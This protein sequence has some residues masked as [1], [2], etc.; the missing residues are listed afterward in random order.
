MAP[1]RTNE[2][3]ISD[4]SDDGAARDAAIQY[5]I[6]WLERRLFFYLRERSDLA[7]VN[8]DELHQMAADFAQDSVLIIIEK[9]AQFAGRSKFTTWAAKIAVHQALGEMRR[10]RWRDLSL[11]ELTQNGSFEPRFL[12]SDQ[13][14][15]ETEAIQKQV[16]AIVMDVMQRDLS[17][18]QRLALYSRLVLGVPIAI[19]AEQM[20]TN[21]NALYKLIHDGRKR[22]KE[23]LLEKGISPEEVLSTFR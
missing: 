3:W 6:T 18:R 17:E 1:E 7:R 14:S 4:L 22:L 12:S 16:M 5:L 15:P 10:A 2:Q 20:Q 21:T 13:R 19:L 9:Y 23:R 8:A 11:D